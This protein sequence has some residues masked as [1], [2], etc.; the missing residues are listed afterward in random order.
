MFSRCKKIHVSGK[1]LVELGNCFDV[2]VL[3]VGSNNLMGKTSSRDRGLWIQKFR[4]L[5]D[6]GEI[7]IFFCFFNTSSCIHSSSEASLALQQFCMLTRYHWDPKFQARLQFSWWQELNLGK[8]FYLEKASLSSS[9]YQKNSGFC[10]ENI[11]FSRSRNYNE[12]KFYISLGML[13]LNKLF[14]H[15][16]SVN[17]SSLP[18]PMC[19]RP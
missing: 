9:N 15:F 3:E 14:D 10:P 7:C 12:V 5:W 2:E 1:I 16:N 17:L 19:K 18:I 11:L 13:P 4:K 6:L 8:G